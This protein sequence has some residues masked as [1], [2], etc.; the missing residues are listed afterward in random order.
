MEN[1]PRTTALI[2]SHNSAAAL[3]RCLAALDSSETRESLEILIVDAGSTDDTRDIENDF[4]AVNFLRLP[5]NFGLTKAR[6]IG[7]RTAKGT[8]L[9]LLRP[10]V[11]VQPT[12]VHALASLME[13]DST[14][15]GVS[16][17]VTSPDGAPDS[18][19]G[20]LPTPAELYRVWST[21]EPWNHR[22][23]PPPP[24]TGDEPFTVDQ[25]DPRAVMVR[26]QAIRGMN[27]IDERYGEFGSLLE[28]PALAARAG[29]RLLLAPAVR[30]TLFDGEGL[31]QPATAAARGDLLAD[32]ASGIVTYS[33]KHYG[34]FSGL[35]VRLRMLLHSLVTFR[36]GLTGRLI[37]GFKI[38]GSQPGP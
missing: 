30:V 16:P 18:H 25:P 4:P 14:L 28:V 8:Y 35:R 33:S 13:G 3:R 6:N 22:L 21:G 26:T 24:I 5:R 15:L 1:T 23:V 27:Y 7:T 29:K 31:W 19:A 9:L 11:E 20:V 17:L 10:D 36:L 34:F 12:T 38:D 32:Y 37:G 2:V